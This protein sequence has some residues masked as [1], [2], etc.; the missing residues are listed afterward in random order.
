M[1]FL[2]GHTFSSWDPML[3][4]CSCP[5]SLSSVRVPPPSSPSQVEVRTLGSSTLVQ[6]LDL[7]K[8]KIVSTHGTALYVAS[9]TDCWR[10]EPVP[11][12]SQVDQLVAV[13]EFKEAMILAVRAVLWNIPR[14]SRCARSQEPRGLGR[15]LV[16]AHPGWG[17]PRL[18][19]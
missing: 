16:G 5:P 6:R 13:E 1:V 17:Y 7:P 4:S 12:S 3:P 18:T 9:A 10:L 15:R 11:L 8:A 19:R 14:P 2:Q